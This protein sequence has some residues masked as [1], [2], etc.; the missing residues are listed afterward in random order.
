VLLEPTSIVAKAW[1][2]I[3]RI[4]RRAPFWKPK[5]ALITGAGPVGLLAAMMGRQ[6]GLELHIL[7]RAKDGPKPALV[8]GLGA[9]YHTGDLGSLKTDVVI[10]CTGAVPVIADAMSRVTPAGIVCLAGVSSVGKKIQ[11]D[12]GD[13]NR[14]TVLENDVVFG[15]VN[16]N[17]AHYEAA[18]QALA[19]AD[20]AWLMRLISRR[21]PLSRWREAF[22]NRPDDIKV[23]VDF[24]AN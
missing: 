20:R 4:G 21:V 16:A 11:F 22:E 7:D 15:S 24:T 3:E 19:K 10:E 17:R 1:D 13:F 18:A 8:N 12:I 14:A 9:T 2:Q 6:R 5:S 23:V